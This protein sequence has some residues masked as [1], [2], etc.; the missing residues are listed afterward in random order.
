M[1][2]TRNRRVPIH[3]LPSRVRIN[4]QK[5]GG[6]RKEGRLCSGVFLQNKPDFARGGRWIL[7]WGPFGPHA[8][9]LFYARILLPWG[10]GESLGDLVT[11][12][13]H[14]GLEGLQV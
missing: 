9:D 5:W 13:D 3:R 10:E 6:W 12:F 7:I 2:F 8:P 11:G 1:D 14:C 4:L